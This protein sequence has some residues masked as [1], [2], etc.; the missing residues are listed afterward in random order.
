L[1]KDV[2]LET[3]ERIRARAHQLWLDEGKP[4]GRH[5]RHWAEAAEIIA[6]EDSPK[7]ALKPVTDEPYGEPIEPPEALE[8]QGEFPVLNDQGE[9]QPR[10]RLPRK[11]STKAGART[12]A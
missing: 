2:F 10:V 9:K 1:A 5:E 7:A 6:L 11:R 4:E 3:E 12:T 8:N